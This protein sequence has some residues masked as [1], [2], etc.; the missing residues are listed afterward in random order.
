[1]RIRSQCLEGKAAMK[2]VETE[3]TQP[4]NLA[5]DALRL[6]VDTTPELIHTGRPD[7]Y[8][9]YFNQ[10]WLDFLGCSLEEVC[11]WRWTDSIHPE[12]VAGMVQKWHGAMSSRNLSKRK[13]ARTARRRRIPLVPSPQGADA[14]WRRRYR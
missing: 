5:E 8:L 7:G 1:M 6:V 13:R 10:R 12:D 3:A 4:L 11:G 9:D 14:R 2:A